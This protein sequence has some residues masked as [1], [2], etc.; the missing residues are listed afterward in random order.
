VELRELTRVTVLD[1]RG[2]MSRRTH[3]PAVRLRVDCKSV[4]RDANVARTPPL[5]PGRKFPL[6]TKA[7]EPDADA[8][9]DRINVDARAAG[10]VRST[11]N[12]VANAVK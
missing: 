5:A 7:T 6:T 12:K 2:A 8:S 10:Y 1:G 9:V 11:F 3:P 4:K